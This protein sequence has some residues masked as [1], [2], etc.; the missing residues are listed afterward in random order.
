MVGGGAA[1]GDGMASV[2]G[3]VAVALGEGDELPNGPVVFAQ[4]DNNTSIPIRAMTNQEGREAARFKRRVG[5]LS[6]QLAGANAAHRRQN[7]RRALLFA[8]VRAVLSAFL[9][10]LSVLVLS[11][12]SGLSGFIFG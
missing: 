1:V 10:D 8:F 2:A 6:I 7:Y 4:A 11:R 3:L 9:A 12:C 5:N